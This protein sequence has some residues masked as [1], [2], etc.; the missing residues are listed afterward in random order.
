[1]HRW[2]EDEMKKQLR[3]QLHLPV[4]ETLH[5]AHVLAQSVVGLMTGANQQQNKGRHKGW[6]SHTFAAK[7]GSKKSTVINY[8]GRLEFQDGK[9]KRYI[10][11][12]EVA[13]Q[14]NRQ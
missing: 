2:V 8:F 9:R 14:Y 5:I 4:A 7:D 3:S 10:N 12:Q 1:M 13:A 6:V 11:L